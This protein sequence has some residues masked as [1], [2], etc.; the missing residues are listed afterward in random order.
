LRGPVDDPLISHSL[1][2]IWGPDEGAEIYGSLGAWSYAAAVQN[3][4]ISQV[5]DYHSS[6]AFAARLG[7][8]PMGWLHLSASAMRTGEVATVSPVTSIGDNLTA[9]WFANAFFRALGP[10]TRTSNFWADLYEGDAVVTW[11]GGQ[12]RA[13]FGQVYFDDSDPLV[14]DSR[15]L[16]YGFIEGQQSITDNLYAAARYSEIQAPGGYPLAGLGNPG[17]YFYRPSFT[18]E[19]RRLSLGLGYRF[20]PPLVLKVEYSWENGHMTNGVARDQEDFFGAQLGL[21]F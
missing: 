10:A 14:D 13:A 18:D 3:G 17:T 16:T 6:K 2:D 9:L 12:A 1:S 20:G 4:G 15:R 8:D 7:W 19:L 21:K 11:K 5:H